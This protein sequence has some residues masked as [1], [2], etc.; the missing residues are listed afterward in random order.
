MTFSGAEI[1]ALIRE[2]QQWFPPRSSL[3]VAL[4]QRQHIH[5]STIST[6]V[7]AVLMFTV[8][9]LTDSNNQRYPDDLHPV[10]KSD[11]DK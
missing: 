5:H 3:H 10:G 1:K 4:S 11:S 7:T 6:R 2:S 8:I 9:T